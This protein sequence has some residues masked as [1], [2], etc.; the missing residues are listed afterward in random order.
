[1]DLHALVANLSDFDASVR[2]DALVKLAAGTPFPGPGSLF[3]MHCHSFFSYNADGWS[4]RKS[5]R[6]NSSH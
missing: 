5:T 3:N 4:D 1:M 6:L 2:R